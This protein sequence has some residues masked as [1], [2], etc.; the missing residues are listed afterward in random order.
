[1]RKSSI[2]KGCTNIVIFVHG[3]GVRSDSRGMFTDIV[4]SLPEGWGSVLSDLSDVDGDNVHILS[5]SDQAKR[6]KEIYGEVHEQH[7]EVTVHLIAH[8]MGCV[9]AI[10]AHLDI[11][12]K[13]VLLAPPS[14][15]GGSALEEYFTHYPGAEK[16]GDKLVVP[17]KDGTISH[18]PYSFFRQMAHADP[19]QIISDYTKQHQVEVIAAAEDELVDTRAYDAF[20]DNARI[21]TLA[22]D[23]NFTGDA[24]SELIKTVT[25][26]IRAS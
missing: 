7:P 1:M 10:E 19:I 14:T 17:R 25:R 24:R 3:F 20:G 26:V 2:P 22:G 15:F 23:H 18:I 11:N 21:T 5:I 9:V 8:S 6:V 4:E 16:Q 13:V 12:G